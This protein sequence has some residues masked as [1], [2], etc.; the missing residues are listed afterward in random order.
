MSEE[1]RQ[2]ITLSNKAISKAIK[3]EVKKELDGSISEHT[4]ITNM[5]ELFE[6]IK[7]IQDPTQQAELYKKLLG[8]LEDHQKV[9]ND[10]LTKLVD[11]KIEEN[12]KLLNN[13][14]HKEKTLLNDQ[15]EKNNKVLKAELD[16]DSLRTNLFSNRWFIIFLMCFPIIAGIFVAI[17]AESFFFGAFL[18]LMWYGMILALYFSQ[19]DALNKLLQ[20]FPI[21]D[22]IEEIK[23]RKI[24]N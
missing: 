18:I 6:S 2:E 19:S 17:L 10:V 16:K 8:M 24:N 7:T 15:I 12:E 21:K 1:I 14:I 5:P 11:S 23:N 20:N 4:A 3:D 9:K 13:Q 22:S